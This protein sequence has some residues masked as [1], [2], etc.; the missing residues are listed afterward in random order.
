MPDDASIIHAMEP[1]EIGKEI[2][3]QGI[4]QDPS[5]PVSTRLQKWLVFS[6]ALALVGI[7][8]DAVASTPHSKGLTMAGALGG[9]ELYM[10][11]ISML[12]SAAGELLYERTRLGN[13]GSWQVTL[14]FC[15][16]IISIFPTTLFALARAGKATPNSVM[17]LSVTFF[18]IAITWG[19]FLI[20]VTGK[21]ASNVP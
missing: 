20:V 5:H 13:A 15:T 1:T 19:V 18:A 12:F 11:A 9:G 6:V 2:V 14:A 10:V 4:D 8:S 16:W 7:G 3:N 17:T 21:G